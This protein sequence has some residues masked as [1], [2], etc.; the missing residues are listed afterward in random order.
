MQKRKE[1]V[2]YIKSKDKEPFEDEMPG[3]GGLGG[4]PDGAPDQAVQPGQ[5]NEMEMSFDEN[6]DS[7]DL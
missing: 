5:R 7:E 6:E 2:E 1:E 4:N 3:F